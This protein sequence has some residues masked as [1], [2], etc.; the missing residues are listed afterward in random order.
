MNYPQLKRRSMLQKIATM[1]GAATM[2]V[3]ASGAAAEKESKFMHIVFFWLKNPD[4][5]SERK[6][7]ETNLNALIGGVDLIR[8]KF[9]GTAAGTPREV[10][11]NSY[12][13][14]MIISFDNKKDQ[15]VYQSHELHLKFIK[16]TE[17]L[18]EKV[19]VYDSI[20]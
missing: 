16:D 12:T 5:K 7:F 19:Q 20:S 3:V 15:D 9:V 18:W 8:S 10:V 1:F 13:Y 6:T 14:C 11:D 17:H 4:N 2:G